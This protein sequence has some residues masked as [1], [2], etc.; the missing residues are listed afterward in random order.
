METENRI[1]LIT[2]DAPDCCDSSSTAGCHTG[3]EP[4]PEGWV[5]V[6][7]WTADGQVFHGWIDSVSRR[8]LQVG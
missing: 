5:I 1:E 8:L 7:H 4:R 3:P 6:E 2:G